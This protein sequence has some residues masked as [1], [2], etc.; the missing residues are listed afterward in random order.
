MTFPIELLD[1]SS[2]S[3]T[4]ELL[5]ALCQLSIAISRHCSKTEVADQRFSC[6]VSNIKKCMQ[7]VS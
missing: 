7:Y 4:F 5:S 2:A 1:P 3:L 6:H